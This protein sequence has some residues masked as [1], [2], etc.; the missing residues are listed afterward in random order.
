M[1]LCFDV[2]C[3]LLPIK[4][5]IFKITVAFVFEGFTVAFLTRSHLLQVRFQRGT[6]ALRC[7]MGFTLD[8][9]APAFH[10]F[11]HSFLCP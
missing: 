5:R 4:T 11:S 9:I 3:V 10:S 2:L 6:L 1:L 8:C 7:I